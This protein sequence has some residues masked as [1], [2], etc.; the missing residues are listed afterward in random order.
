MAKPRFYHQNKPNR[1]EGLGGGAVE[2]KGVEAEKGTVGDGGKD[3]ERATH[4]SLSPPA[5]PA[6]GRERANRREG[7]AI[8]RK[9]E[10]RRR[11]RSPRGQKLE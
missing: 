5:E 8:R 11:S 3:K 7:R 6:A 9:T 10:E 4:D 1:S 2:A